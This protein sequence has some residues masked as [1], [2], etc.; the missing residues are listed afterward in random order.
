LPAWRKADR[1]KDVATVAREGARLV[2]LGLQES[3]ASL[4]SLP[5]RPPI[6]RRGRAARLAGVAGQNL[7]RTP[8]RIFTEPAI[9]GRGRP[10]ERTGS[11]TFF[12]FSLFLV[13]FVA[14]T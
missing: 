3:E 12:A 11:V 7:A 5:A 9:G 1:I 8:V 4:P 14:E 10:A 2:R 6:R 13:P